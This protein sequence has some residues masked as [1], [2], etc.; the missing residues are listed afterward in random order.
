[1]KIDRRIRHAV[2]YFLPSDRDAHRVMI[3][4][5]PNLAVR[6]LRVFDPDENL[7][8]EETPR[9]W[10]LRIRLPTPGIVACPTREDG[11]ACRE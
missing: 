10:I 6:G 2:N 9:E 4:S 1:M 3:I 8:R 11:K 7:T 5:S